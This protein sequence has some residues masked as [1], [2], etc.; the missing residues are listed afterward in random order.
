MPD[1][2]PYNIEITNDECVFLYYSLEVMKQA[3]SGSIPYDTAP[4]KVGLEDAVKYVNSVLRIRDKAMEDA[5]GG[6]IEKAQAFIDSLH[7]KI[8]SRMNT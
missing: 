1:K 4:Y 5:A 3:I 6:D 7:K 2:G 8:T